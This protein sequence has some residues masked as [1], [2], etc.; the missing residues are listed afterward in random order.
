ME[1][2]FKIGVTASALVFVAVFIII[3]VPAAL[4]L[5][6]NLFVQISTALAGGYVNPFATGY[7]VDATACWFILL[8]WVMYEA[9]EYKVKHGWI[10]MIIGAFPGIAAGFALYLILRHKQLFEAKHG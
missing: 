1:K 7:A 4:A 5:D 10:C 3:C 2:L 8:F 6:G 9:M